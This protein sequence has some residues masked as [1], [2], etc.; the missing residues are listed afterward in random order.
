ML[1]NQVG[2][3]NE[4]VKALVSITDEGQMFDFLRDLLTENEMENLAV[5]LKCAYLLHSGKTYT[6]VIEETKL[7]STTLSR[8][9]RCLRQGT[10]YNAML[11]KHDEAVKPKD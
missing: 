2:V 7:S 11:D 1:K 3:T 4:L 9:S 5:R 8:I 10:G 6:K